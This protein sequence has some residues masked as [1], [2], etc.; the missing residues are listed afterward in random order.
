MHA[1]LVFPQAFTKAIR[2][3]H[4]R[5]AD[6]AAATR[7]PPLAPASARFLAAEF[8]QYKPLAT[9]PSYDFLRAL[10][11]ER[12]HPHSQSEL[13]LIAPIPIPCPGRILS[14]IDNY[15]IYTAGGIIMESPV[16]RQLSWQEMLDVVPRL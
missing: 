11:P 15:S 2:L 6:T 4:H 5:V 16:L 7:N 10:R 12:Q 3:F 14:D 1:R 8:L 13:F 9:H